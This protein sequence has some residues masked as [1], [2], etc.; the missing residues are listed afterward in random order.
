M[1]G[2]LP[3]LATLAGANAVYLVLLLTGGMV[4]P[5]GELPRAGRHDREGAARGAAGRDPDR[6]AERWRRGELGVG[7]ARHLGGGGSDRR[8]GVFRWE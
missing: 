7:L 2:T 4:I 3:G 5:L 1:A 6:I 8:R